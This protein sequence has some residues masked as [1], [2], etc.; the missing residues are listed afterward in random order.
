MTGTMVEF[1]AT[2][3]TDG[4]TASGYL[5]LPPSGH[6][7]GLLVLQEWWGLVDHIKVL[8][9]RFAAAGFVALAPDLYRGEQATTP[10]DAERLLMALDMPHT[11][12]A[13]RGGAAYLREL[14][15]VSPKKVGAIGF[16]MGGQ[17]ALYSATAHP[18]VI[19]AVVDFYGIFNPKVPVDLSALRA[20]VQAHF[21]DHD[22]SIP[23]ARA[24]ALMA[25]VAATGVRAEAYFYDAGHAFFNDTR[26]AVYNPDAAALAWERTIEFLQQSLA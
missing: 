20:P 2:S 21:G 22:T 9:D 8:A 7:P 17:L 11:A 18:D 25:E 24:D 10:G 15:A 26:A 1:R 14:D 16:C 3:G 6:G 5:S 13:L 12:G 4:G 23:R 19:D